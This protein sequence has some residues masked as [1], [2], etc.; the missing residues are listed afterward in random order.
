[1]Q[2]SHII[3]YCDY[4]VPLITVE[5]FDVRNFTQNLT[6]YEPTQ[7]QGEDYYETFSCR[8]QAMLAGVTTYKA[9]FITVH[10]FESHKFC[11]KFIAMNGF[12]G[13]VADGAG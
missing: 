3:N 7:T 6:N 8:S 11:S 2:H 1:M 4:G 12:L 5:V 9:H 10:A 13:T